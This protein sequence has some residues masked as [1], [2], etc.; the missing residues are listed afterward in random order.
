M[1]SNIISDFMVLVYNDQGHNASTRFIDDD[2]ECNTA[3]NMEKNIA[4]DTRDNIADDMRYYTENIEDNST[5]D[6]KGNVD[7]TESND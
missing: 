6:M 5:G 1:H 7:N 2:T 4:D 3:G